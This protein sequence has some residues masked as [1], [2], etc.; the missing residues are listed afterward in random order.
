[1]LSFL[2]LIISILSITYAD[3]SGKKKVL[4][5]TSEIDSIPMHQMMIE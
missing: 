3:T 2:F 5:I 4:L 1:M